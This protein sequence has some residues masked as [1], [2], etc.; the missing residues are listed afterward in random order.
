M[1]LVGNFTQNYDNTGATGGVPPLGRQ[2]STQHANHDPTPI[3]AGLEEKESQ[4]GGSSSEGET[5]QIKRDQTTL[6]LARRM[7]RQSTDQQTGNPFDVEKDGPLDP[8]SENFNSRAWTKAL[9]NL[10]Q[11]ESDKFKPRTAGF[12]FKDLNVYGYGSATDYQKSVGNVIF[13]V[14]GLAKKLLG[15][16]KPRKIDILQ[17]LD[18]V[19][20][21]GEMLV[22]LGP[23]GS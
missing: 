16:S 11:Q 21:A 15:L 14:Y 2:P 4:E 23:P 12:A 18:G 8:W 1:S 6:N 17:N 9:L 3:H 7:S 10:E 20:H 19:V 22:V 13:E 5:E